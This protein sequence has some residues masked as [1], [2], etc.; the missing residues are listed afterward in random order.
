MAPKLPQDKPYSSPDITCRV[1]GSWTSQY[2]WLGLRSGVVQRTHLIPAVTYFSTVVLAESVAAFGRQ[3]EG[4][5]MAMSIHVIL[6]FTLLIHSALLSTSDD[7]LAKFLAVLSLAP[8]IRILSLGLP[9]TPFTIIQW[10]FIISIPLVA[11]GIT[12]MYVMGLKP[13]D[14][15]LRLMSAR[16]GLVQGGVVL[17]GF[18]LGA[19]EYFILVPEEP[20]VST[21]ALVEFLPA[22]AAIVLASGL[23]EE[24]IFRGLLLPKSEAILGRLSGLI[25]VSLLFAAMHIGFKSVLDLIFVFSVGFYF[26]FVVQKTRNLFGVIFA[27]G[28]AN[29]A[30]YLIL[31]VYL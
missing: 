13:R 1:R 28:F 19:A 24:L 5:V 2:E 12:I 16:Q 8:L 22:V 23:A 4:F 17:S 31:P 29:V 26:G 25:F 30:L 11:G 21:L 10:L 6:M 15:Y 27:H 9:F 3:P 20:W 14:V 7:R 18:S